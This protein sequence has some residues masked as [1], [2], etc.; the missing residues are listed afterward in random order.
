VARYEVRVY[1]AAERDLEDIVDYLNTLSPQIAVQCYEQLVDKLQS[2]SNMPQRCP[3]I[4]ELAL[5]AKGYRYLIVEDY[6][7]CFVIRDRTV[8]IRRIIH[9]RRNYEPLL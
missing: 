5:K 9:G 2:L 4:R 6:L 8:Q 3:L 7:V 1:P